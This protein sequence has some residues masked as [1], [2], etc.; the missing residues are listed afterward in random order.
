MMPF[1]SC[2][3]WVI[4]RSMLEHRRSAEQHHSCRDGCFTACL[5]PFRPPGL[6][7]RWRVRCILYRTEETSFNIS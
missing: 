2:V 3:G 7:N 1:M 6:G 4:Q 5:L